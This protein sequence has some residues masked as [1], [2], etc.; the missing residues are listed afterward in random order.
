MTGEPGS[1]SSPQDQDGGSGSTRRNQDLD[2]KNRAEFVVVQEPCI[3]QS[4]GKTWTA[5]TLRRCSGGYIM[6][7]L[8]G[9]NALGYN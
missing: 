8:T 7:Y 6:L 4:S 2:L 1:R 5:G 9:V 3:A